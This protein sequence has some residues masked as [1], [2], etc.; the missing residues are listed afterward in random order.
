M[1]S[2]YFLLIYVLG[3]VT[4]CTFFLWCGGTVSSKAYSS[5]GVLPLR[6]IADL[7]LT[8]GTT[9]FD[10]QSY[11]PQTGLLFIAHLGD[12]VVMVFD[13]QSQKVIK[14]IPDIGSVHGVL[15]VPELDR[16][17]ASATETKPM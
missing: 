6:K 4:A 10:Y 12:S 16:V 5:E 15:A 14:D 2:P 7:L 9:R 13:T 3:T 11:D 1:K 8:G 17:Y